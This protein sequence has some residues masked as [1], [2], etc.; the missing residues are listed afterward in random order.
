MRL[1]KRCGQ[2]KPVGNFRAKHLT[3]SDCVAASRRE[4]SQVIPAELVKKSATLAEIIEAYADEL[5]QVSQEM[6]DLKANDTRAQRVGYIS[7]R[8]RDITNGRG[9]VELAKSQRG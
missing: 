2:A 1:C 5:W 4:K 6:F 7:H 3:C 8:L 9:F